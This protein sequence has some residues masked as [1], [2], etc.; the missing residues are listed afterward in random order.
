M[1]EWIH[2]EDSFRPIDLDEYDWELTDDEERI[3]DIICETVGELEG[4]IEN[5]GETVTISRGTAQKAIQLIKAYTALYDLT[6][7]DYEDEYD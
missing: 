1:N 3:R 6:L 5:I 2:D 7:D 4:A